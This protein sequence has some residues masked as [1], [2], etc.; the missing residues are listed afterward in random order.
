MFGTDRSENQV[1][2]QGRAENWSDA[3]VEYWSFGQEKFF[4]FR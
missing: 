3:V 4:G 2:C 1:R